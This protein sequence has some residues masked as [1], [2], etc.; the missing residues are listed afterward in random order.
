[1]ISITTYRFKE[2]EFIVIMLKE[3]YTIRITEKTVRVFG[4]YG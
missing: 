3:C 1:M 4:L 2:E